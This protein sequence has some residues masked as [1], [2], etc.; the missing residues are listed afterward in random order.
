MTPQLFPEFSNIILPTQSQA[1]FGIA[2]GA[3]MIAGVGISTDR[4]FFGRHRNSVLFGSDATRVPD[5][6]AGSNHPSRFITYF[7]LTELQRYFGIRSVK[8][9]H[10]W[11]GTVGYTP[12]E[13][14]LVGTMD[15][16][17]VYIIGGMAGSGSGVSFNAARHVV[18]KILNIPGPD[19]YPEKYFSPARFHKKPM[20]E[21]RQIDPAPGDRKVEL[22]RS[23]FTHEDGRNG[24]PNFAALF[25]V[26]ALSL[27]G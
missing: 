4:S 2:D 25:S 12:D 26:A 27:S 20:P 11:S 5:R 22:T 9:T 10:K 23:S 6:A 1:A 21:Q 24:K 8:V 19:Y 17:R 15:G 7:V 14:P 13:Y 3:T 16:K 18:H